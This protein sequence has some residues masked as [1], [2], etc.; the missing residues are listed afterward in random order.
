MNTKKK[1]MF[2]DAL[3]ELKEDNKAIF[4]MKLAVIRLLSLK[5]VDFIEKHWMDFF[6]VEPSDEVIKY[7]GGL[8]KYKI[9][10]RLWQGGEN[11]LDQYLVEVFIEVDALLI[12]M[13]KPSNEFN[14]RNYYN[15]CKIARS[16]LINISDPLKFTLK[17]LIDNEHTSVV[18]KRFIAPYID[19]IKDIHS[20]IK[21]EVEQRGIFESDSNESTIE[22]KKLES[23]NAKVINEK[24][25]RNALSEV[26]FMKR[27]LKKVDSDSYGNVLSK[28]FLQ[29]IKGNF[30]SQEELVMQIENLFYALESFGIETIEAEK[31]EK[32][33]AFDETMLKSR[34]RLD[35]DISK[36]DMEAIDIYMKYA[37]WSFDGEIVKQPIL[38][39]RRG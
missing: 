4:R 30:A 25:D 27:L 35:F 17:N 3:R 6:V 24:K 13:G 2:E 20:I 8:N 34:Y 5:K 36:V 32:K 9:C 19:D 23:D 7:I 21:N 16:I 12:Y 15:D 38:S 14:I 18:I 1:F 22:T 11:I 29:H 33:I 28:L 26:E 31:I 39:F 37:G 10:K